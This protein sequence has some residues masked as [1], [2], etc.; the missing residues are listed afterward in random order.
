M[1]LTKKYSLPDALNNLKVEGGTPVWLGTEINTYVS[2]KRSYIEHYQIEETGDVFKAKRTH[3]LRSTV[4]GKSQK[5]S[6]KPFIPRNWVDAD[7]D[8]VVAE[9]EKAASE[10]IATPGFNES[11]TLV[12]FLNKQVADVKRRAGQE[13][14][15]RELLREDGKACVVSRVKEALEASHLNYPGESLSLRGVTLRRDLAWLFDYS[16]AKLTVREDGTIFWDYPG[17]EFHGKTLNLTSEKA[18]AVAAE[19]ATHR[20]QVEEAVA[21]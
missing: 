17:H 21:A 15:R 4:G 5:A 16:D 13:R 19:L 8:A 18:K 20:P 14:W 10:A 2:G 11:P 6:T 3:L 1:N 12:Q 9:A 7:L